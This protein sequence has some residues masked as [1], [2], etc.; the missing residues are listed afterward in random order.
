M[1]VTM[2]VKFNNTDNSD[3]RFFSMH[4]G[5]SIIGLD[6]NN[7]VGEKLRL[8]KHDSSTGNYFS[9][10]WRYQAIT[11]VPSDEWV[12]VGFVVNNLTPSVNTDFTMFLH[13]S[14]GYTAS[15]NKSPSDVSVFDASV[16]PEIRFGDVLNNNTSM[17]GAVDEI[18]IWN[19]TLTQT[20]I[21]DIY[22]AG[23]Q[24]DLTQ[25]ADYSNIKYWLLSIVTGKQT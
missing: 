23:L 3:Q 13:D 14:I 24:Q 6:Y 18:V 8:R 5:S 25:R 22:N 2:W 4:S 7:G 1:T 20:D 16:I 9:G 12:L 11:S 15:S 21:E 19:K 10:F 17:S